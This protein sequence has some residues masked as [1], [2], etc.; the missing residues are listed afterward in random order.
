MVTENQAKT[1]DLEEIIKVL[2]Q[3]E[4]SS[5]EQLLTFQKQVNELQDRLKESNLVVS[6]NQQVKKC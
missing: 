2:K 6:S 4:V 1:R 3:N 5:G